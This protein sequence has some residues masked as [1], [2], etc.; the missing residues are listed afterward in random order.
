VSLLRVFIAIPEY[1]SIIIYDP[2]NSTLLLKNVGN[3]EYD[4]LIFTFSDPTGKEYQIEKEIDIKI[5]EILQINWIDLKKDLEHNKMYYFKDL[6]ALEKEWQYIPS[7]DTGFRKFMPLRLDSIMIGVLAG[8][9]CYYYNDF[10]KKKKI[11]CAI[12]GVLILLTSGLYFYYSFDTIITKPGTGTF[13]TKTFLFNAIGIGTALL[14]PLGYYIKR[15]KNE[16]IAKLIVHISLISY[17]IYL[18][19]LIIIGL[20]NKLPLNNI[21]KLFIVLIWI[22]V[23]ST[24]QYRLF[25][26]P[27]TS[28]REKFSK[29]EEV[30]S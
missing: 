2:E 21:N 16:F 26:K 18:I 15:P 1:D 3:A 12:I 10:W 25:E 11:K 30:K 7:W 23:I 24:L 9:I 17:S 6:K 5:N 14:F 13:F 27:I 20:V 22:F 4:K 29:K 8:I 19:H 28:I